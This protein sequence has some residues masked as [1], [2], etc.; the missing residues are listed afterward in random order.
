MEQLE[1]LEEFTLFENRFEIL[2][3]LGGGGM[4]AVYKA[5]QK[6]ADRIVA[7]KL[8]HPSLIETDEFRKRFLRECKLLSQLSNEHIITFYHA[9]ISEDGYP[10]AVFE[11]L[12]GQTLRQLLSAKQL[13][14]LE[15]IEILLQ[16]TEALQGAHASNIVHR[17]L[18]PEN[19]M[20]TSRASNADFVK[21]FDFG[22]SKNSITEERESQKLTL[23]GDLVGTAAYMSPEQC[24]GERAD[25]RSDIYALGCIAYECL[26]GNQLFDEATSMAAL[27]KHLHESPTNAINALSTSIPP[28][29][30]ELLLEMLAKS[31]DQRPRTMTSVRDALLNAQIQARQGI[32]S[33]QKPSKRISAK[34]VAIAAVLLVSVILPLTGLVLNY[35]HEQAVQKSKLAENRKR[36]KRAKLEEQNFILGSELIETAHQELEAQNFAQSIELA[37]KVAGLKNESCE[38][39]PIRLRAY[40]IWAQAGHFSQL[41]DPDPPL[42]KLGN[43]LKESAARNCL[44]DKEKTDWTFSYLLLATN[45]HQTKGRQRQA[46]TCTEEYEKLYNSVPED[47]KQKVQFVLALI[48]RGHSYRNSKQFEKALATDQRAFELAKKLEAEGADLLYSI[49][50]SLFFDIGIGKVPPKKVAELQIE[51][52]KAFEEKFS[53]TNSEGLMRSILAA[54]DNVLGQA[55]YANTGDALILTAWKAAK[56]FPEISTHLRMRALQQLLHLRLRQAKNG[57]VDT[58]TLVQIANS[59]L[60]IL[61]EAKAPSLG[62][63][64]FGSRK[65]LAGELSALLQA[66]SQK[67]LALKVQQANQTFSLDK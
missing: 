26:S 47:Q 11:Y 19:I 4:G 67:D 62:P 27:H 43:L 53:S 22:L 33:V 6:D 17:D 46:I 12:Q 10:Y 56:M 13:S 64:Y 36:A 7:L 28:A 45:V 55:Q 66:S 20:V 23:T 24:R 41:C 9:A 48:S 25:E 15:C 60:L 40:R 39:V 65:E 5:N 2:G 54:Q 63:S 38:Y 21:V 42:V 49:Y 52:A 18:K 34:I 57:K 44:S 58:K 51:Y 3:F 29:L 50:P 35:Q 37:S 14:V 32:K 8:L 30:T 61:S 59:Y 16:V 31:P 1:Q